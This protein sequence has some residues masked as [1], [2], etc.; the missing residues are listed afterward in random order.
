M[1]TITETPKWPDNTGYPN[2]RDGGNGPW[3]AAFSDVPIFHWLSQPQNKK[4]FDDCNTF[5]EGDRGSRPSWVDWFPVEQKLLRGSKSDHPLLV[6]VAGGR[7]HDV[8]EFHNHFPD[9]RGKLVLQDQQAV[10]DSITELPSA[11]E[12]RSIDFF[13][14]KPVTGMTFPSFCC[15][16]LRHL[17]SAADA[18]LQTLEFTS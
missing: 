9:H 17:S 6:D 5:F 1:P 11:V 3:Q 14:E 15:E 16:P 12:K 10:L 8:I 4:H 2:P 13:K 18:Y 7:G